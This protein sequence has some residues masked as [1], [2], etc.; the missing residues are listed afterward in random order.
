MVGIATDRERRRVGDRRRIVRS[1]VLARGAFRSFLAQS[2]VITRPHFGLCA[3]VCRVAGSPP[4][5]RKKQKLEKGET[6]MRQLNSLTQRFATAASLMI[7][8]ASARR[9]N[10]DITLYDNDG[11]SFHTTGLVAAHYQLVL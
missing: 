10:A 1:T 8:T 11:W 7:L 4:A 9:A 3:S 5:V 2:G 6:P